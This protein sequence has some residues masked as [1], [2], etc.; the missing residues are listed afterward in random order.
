[1][2]ILIERNVR[3][4]MRD[5][6]IL[7]SDVYRPADR[8]R[9]PCLVQR[10]PYSKD[11]PTFRDYAIDIIRAVSN[12]YAVLI[13]D[14]R[15]RFAS[16]GTFSPFDNEDNDGY[17]TIEW[18]AQAPWSTGQIGM[19][20]GSYFGFTQ[21][22]AARAQPHALV[23][24]APYLAASDPYHDF[25]YQGG[26]FA[27]GFSLRWALTSL[28][29]GDTAKKIRDGQGSRAELHDLWRD[30]D[31][32]DDLYHI[33]PLKDVPALRERAP[34][35][36]DWLSHPS[37]DDYWRAKTCRPFAGGQV[38]ALLI[39]GWYDIFLRGALADYTAAKASGGP[40]PR[41]VIGP[42][43]HGDQTGTF[44]HRSF[45]THSGVDSFDLTGLTLRWF[46]SHMRGGPSLAPV[47]VFVMGADEWRDILDWPHPDATPTKFFL[48]SHGYANSRNGDGVLTFVS[49]RGDGS[50]SFIYDPRNPTPT[51]GGCTFLPGSMVGLNSGPRDQRE[52][53][54]RSDV[55]CYTSP[56]LEKDIE[57]IGTAH[58]TI[59]VSS[60]A[61]DTDFMVA[62]VDVAP[63]G[64]SALVCDGI[65]R[66]RYR[67][68]L[69]S[70]CP[71]VPTKVY[72][73]SI[74]IGA[75]AIRFRSDHRI[76]IDI[77]SSNFPRFD[78]NLNTAG[79][80]GAEDSS[81]AQQ[82]QNTVYHGPGR[83]SHV[84]LPVIK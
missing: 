1:M 8:Q 71:L 59:Y 50:D 58:A 12:G 3:L 10:T 33:L 65:L 19:V 73:L 9:H 30:A 69:S 72:R 11:S 32:I 16:G 6:T 5:G 42:W 31:A 13:Q 54:E 2:N 44:P 63:D 83:P 15:G 29:G 41:L 37:F 82:A 4:R 23:A 45:G 34:Y 25:C 53:E 48:D 75:T 62:I 43:A 22:Q 57:V 60:S 18:A 39:A 77:S 17:D 66:A 14:V 35:Y 61:R 64:Q 49:P 46:D 38:P 70:P 24:I 84:V 80:I 68:S 21:W 74:D 20:G 28:A 52:N 55:L 51:A 76:R 56:P 78:R 67:D 27:L 36:F 40:E 47:T 7:A 79:E 81:E 26:A